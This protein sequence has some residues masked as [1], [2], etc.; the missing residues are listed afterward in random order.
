[1]PRSMEFLLSLALLIAFS[2]LLLLCGL[3]VAL[4]SRGPVIFRQVRVGKGGGTFVLFKFRTMRRHD[5]GPSLTMENDERVT[6]V[7]RFLRRSHLDEL[8]QLLNILKGDMSFVGPRPEVAEFVDV[9]RAKAPELLRVRP[10][11]TDAGTLGALDEGRV[12]SSHA[13]PI[14]YYREHLL[15]EK[16]QRSVEALKNRG[17]LNDL[18]VLFQTMTA[19]SFMRRRKEA[20]DEALV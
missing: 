20:P 4:G 15:P 8:P 13:D 3:M 12:L 10:G 18:C 6:G 2:W 9:I 16:L 11:L 19:V 1:M 14:Q 5:H 7:G 17:P